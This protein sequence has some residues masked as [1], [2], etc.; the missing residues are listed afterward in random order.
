MCG[1]AAFLAYR[2]SPPVD[3]AELDRVRDAMVR[4]GPDGAGT[5]MGQDD[6]VGLAHRRLSII[7]VSDAGLQPMAS[8]DGRTRI[9]FNGE[10]Y[11]YRQL[12]DELTQRGERF[13]SHSDTEVVLA[14]YRRDG[15]AMLGRLRGMFA[16]AIWD[17]NRQ[18][19]LLAR[20][21]LG[22]KPLY[23]ADDGRCLRVASQCRALLAGGAVPAS[24]SPAG[25]VSFLLWGHV[26][27]PFTAWA[28]I[29]ALPAGRAL[30]VGA[31]GS[32]AEHDFNSLRTM[33]VEAEA[34]PAPSWTAES[35]RETLLDSMRAHLIADVPLGVFLSGGLDSTTLAGLAAELT[36]NPL[37]TVTLGFDEF[38]GTPGDETPLAETVARLYGADH[39]TA[40]VS[41]QDFA[42]SREQVLAA[43]DQPSVDGVNTW[44]VSRAA[45]GRGLKVA[46]SGLGGDELFG[47][48]DSFH[49]IPRLVRALRPLGCVPFLGKGF[50]LATSAWIGRFASPK[51]AGLLELGTSFG[52]AYLL[53][54]GLF[55]PWELPRV[56]DADLVREGWRD[57]AARSHLAAMVEDLRSDR[58]RVGALEAGGYMRNQLLR[59]SD[60]AGM[61]HSLEIRV[62]LV[63]VDLY[64]ALLPAMAGANPPGKRHMALSPRPGLLPT[65]L[66]RPKTGFGIPVADWI[67]GGRGLRGWARQVDS[68]FF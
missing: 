36:P 49:Q 58:I 35:L 47:G 25:R 20:D 45:A 54:R 7:D 37:K 26:A 38:A 28:A 3:R 53:R 61:A 52:D 23:L 33:L 34:A 2:G 43:M 30:W 13:C 50:R 60:W 27:E 15:I 18:G 14:L 11:N 4:R 24:P 51:L 66:D 44:F 56:L 62:P 22:I 17:E 48:Y 32:R 8:E 42:A 57:L 16:L 10:I 9:V 63:D 55:M 40:R 12:R 46:L 6:R 29:T 41:A 67:G 68:H 64:R 19:L 21:P 5:W 65:I 31:D 1:L 39:V 59:D